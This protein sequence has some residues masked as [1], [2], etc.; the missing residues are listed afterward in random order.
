VDVSTSWFSPLPQELLDLFRSA[1]R[2]AFDQAI[3]QGLAES[4]AFRALYNFRARPFGIESPFD[5]YSAVATYTLAGVAQ[6]I[7]CPTFIADPAGEQFW[8]GQSQQLYDAVAGEKVLVPFTAGEG[9]YLHTEPMACALRNQRIFD[10][11]DDVLGR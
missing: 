5:L 8:P 11:L 4:P 3:Q 1:N 2:A 9:A 6:R 10:W 7:S